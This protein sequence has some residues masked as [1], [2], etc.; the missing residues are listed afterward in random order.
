MRFASLIAA[1]ALVSFS[2]N[3][4]SPVQ[5]TRPA[6]AHKAKPASHVKPAKHA[7]HARLTDFSKLLKPGAL[8]KMKAVATD[9]VKNA[10]SKGAAKAHDFAT[11]KVKQLF[12][13]IDLE[14]LERAVAVALHQGAELLH[15]KMDGFAKQ[16]TSKAGA[17]ASA[18][19]HE[20][21]DHHKQFEQ[22]IDGIMAKLPGSAK[23][24]RL[25]KL[26]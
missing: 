2:A 17:T 23:G 4:R 8:A 5:Q 6:P 16:A 13:K 19:F 14:T 24:V 9:L 11:A 15:Q 25:A 3:A 18:K 7:H 12:P 22:S 26:F 20:F 10:E 21:I 1:I